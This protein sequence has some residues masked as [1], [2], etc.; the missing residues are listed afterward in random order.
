M[1]KRIES[2]DLIRTIAI[3]LVVLCHSIEAIYNMGLIEWETLSLKS[4]FFRMT[5]FTLSRI[6]VPLFLFLSGCLLLEK[7]YEN[8]NSV[9]NFYLKNFLNL[10]IC[11][12]IW[13]ILYTIF[14]L[15]F[16]V[17]SWSIVEG[18][19][20]LFFLKQINLPNM[21]YMPM[22]LGLY[23]FIPVLGVV[24]KK[25]NFEYILLLMIPSIFVLFLLPY[26]NKVVY[27]LYQI[28]FNSELNLSFSGGVYGI[29]LIF[30]FL[31]YNQKI[32]KKINN[33]LLMIIFFISFIGTCIYQIAMFRIKVNY[34]LWYDFIGILICSMILFEL[35]TRLKLKLTNR[36]KSLI[37]MIS[38]ISLGIF[39]VH[40][41][42]IKLL[43]YY[44]D[45]FV[46]NKPI[47]VI[48]LCIITF[49]MSTIFILVFQKCS[50]I[51]KRIFMIK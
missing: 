43:T 39:F 27:A 49:I 44:F 9:K 32:L 18:I 7:N 8:E 31:I 51:K 47:T 19:E 40:I 29:Y 1:K 50:F 24:V 34:N 14:L 6:G 38:K 17:R 46:I 30:G 5:F 26:I 2:L 21:W 22:I 25:F 28:K 37:T 45:F 35:L 12:E 33:K 10:F 23:L 4:Q 3:L 16:P 13:N 48:S 41:I 15:I 42:I 36:M 20:S 11:I